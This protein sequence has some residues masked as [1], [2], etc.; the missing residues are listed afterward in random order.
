MLFHNNRYH[1]F[2]RRVRNPQEG[3]P[4]ILHLSIRDNQRSAAHD[5][6]DFQKIKNE[7]VGP[8]FEMVEVYPCES[9]LVDL[10]NQFHLWGFYYWRAC[11][12]KDGAWL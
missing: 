7:L 11:L 1:V 9:H 2:M 12:Y 8:E 3:G 10:S 4:D 5:W 6:R